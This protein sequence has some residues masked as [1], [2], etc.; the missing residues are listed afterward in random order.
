MNQD[1]I[2]NTVNLTS[3]EPGLSTVKEGLVDHEEG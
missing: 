2:T 1:S 3:L